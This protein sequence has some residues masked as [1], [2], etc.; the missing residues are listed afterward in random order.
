MHTYS[1]GGSKENIRHTVM[2]WLFVLSIILCTIGN[3]ILDSINTN[4]SALFKGIS[5]FFAKWSWLGVSISTFSAFAIFGF[6]F[7]LF[8]RYIWKLGVVKKITGIPNFS[9]EWEGILKSS[10]DKTKDISIK[11]VIQQSWSKISVLCHF[12]Q[13]DSWSDTAYINPEHGKGP[14]LKFT[15]ANCAQSVSW[16]VKEHRGDNELFL[17]QYDKLNKRYTTLNGDYFNNRGEH[18][19]VGYIELKFVK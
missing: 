14:M 2:L 17:G 9:G 3:Q 13:S 18:G 15:Y 1:L 6:L 19:N 4:N 8:D 7:W 10:F 5:S 12:T 16:E 11:V